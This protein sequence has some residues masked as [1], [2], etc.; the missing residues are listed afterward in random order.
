MSFTRTNEPTNEPTLKCKRSKEEEKKKG[1]EMPVELRVEE[2][3]FRGAAICQRERERE[4]KPESEDEKE[5][6]NWFRFCS[7]VSE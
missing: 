2:Q 1:R 4:S 5:I 3:G 6:R 7:R